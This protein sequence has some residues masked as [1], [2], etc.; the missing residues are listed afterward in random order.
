MTSTN[1]SSKMNVRGMARE[2][3]TLTLLG[4]CFCLLRGRERSILLSLYTTRASV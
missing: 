2:P 1:V 3:E 4:R